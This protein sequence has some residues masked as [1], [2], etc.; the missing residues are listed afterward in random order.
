MMLI[1]GKTKSINLDIKAEQ[2]LIDYDTIQDLPTLLL[3][4]GLRTINQLYDFLETYF[5]YAK[6][7][8][9]K[10][11]ILIMIQI[12]NQCPSIIHKTIDSFLNFTEE[13]LKSLLLKSNLALDFLIQNFELLRSNHFAIN[14]LID[15]EP[16]ETHA[17]NPEYSE[18]LQ[19]QLHKF[20]Y[21]IDTTIYAGMNRV[22]NAISKTELEYVR[23]RKFKD[24]IDESNFK[25]CFQMDT[26]FNVLNNNDWLG[27]EE[28]NIQLDDLFENSYMR[29]LE[30][31]AEFYCYEHDEISFLPYLRS[32]DRSYNI[33]IQG[34]SGTRIVLAKDI[35]FDDI[36]SLPEKL[37][38]LHEDIEIFSTKYTNFLNS[39]KEMN[40]E[41]RMS[42]DSIIG[43]IYTKYPDVLDNMDSNDLRE[44]IDELSNSEKTLTDYL[45]SESLI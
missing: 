12:S 36:D 20:V 32:E 28:R 19:I 13:D 43:D 17:E 24:Y 39:I 38:E 30:S 11:L 41:I 29:H 5:S 4:S 35:D 10:N 1:K 8:S 26:R 22:Y 2:L 25:L 9:Q 27:G 31:E 40:K 34:R 3:K 37:N 15:N 14:D 16:F 18:H 21:L 7:E 23:N 44:I 33:E 45:V 6:K 42:F